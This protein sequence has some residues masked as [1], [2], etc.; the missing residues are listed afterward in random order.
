MAKILVAYY[1]RTGNTE[2]MAQAIAE[3]A[4]EAGHE[5][6][7]K[8]VNDVKPSSLL[9]YDGY[10]FG[11]PVYYGLPAAPL[12]ELFDESVILHKR[13]SGRVGGAFASSGNTGGGNETT[14]MA[15]LQMMLVH[16]MLAV[17]SAEGDH[18]GP[19]AVGSPDSRALAQCKALGKRVADFA[20]KVKN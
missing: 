12:V 13:L 7:L 15:I 1:S 4:K 9:D 6:E 18:Y 5:V 14:C 10:V 19:V 16:G 11:S 3:G 20:A 2:K 8:K 17:G